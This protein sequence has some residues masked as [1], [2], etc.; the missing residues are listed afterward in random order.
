MAAKPPTFPRRWRIRLRACAAAAVVWAAAGPIGAREVWKMSPAEFAQSPAGRARL[1]LATF[2][3]VRLGAAIFHE[4]NRVRRE[5]NLPSFHHL[6]RLDRAADIQATTNAL[7]HDAS[8]HNAIPRVA[9]PNDR[10]QHVGLRPRIVAENAALVPLLDL[11][12]SHGYVEKQEDGTRV[13]LDGQTLREA[14]P[15]TYASFAAALVRSWMASP[16]HRANIVNPQL[17]FL[18]CSGR[19]TKV[20][21]GFDMVACIQEFYTPLT[22]D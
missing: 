20:L 8:H 9:L 14:P 18:G 17:T 19:P 6:D 15:H 7:N 5:L 4:T 1:D 21:G 12:L 22:R 3:P 11:D 16:P 13:I 2:D 10:V